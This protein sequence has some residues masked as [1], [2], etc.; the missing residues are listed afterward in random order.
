MYNTYI[1]RQLSCE[2]IGNDKIILAEFAVIFTK[3][4][5]I[6]NYETLNYSFKIATNDCSS[7]NVNC[8]SGS[9]YNMITFAN[10]KWKVNN[11]LMMIKNSIVCMSET[12]CAPF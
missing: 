10:F 5:P 1:S 9:L 2:L 11:K 12:K 7:L 4:S 3:T 6:D 8:F